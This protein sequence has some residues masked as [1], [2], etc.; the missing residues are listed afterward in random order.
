[1]TKQQ[2]D[3][4][5]KRLQAERDKFDDMICSGFVKVYPSKNQERQQLYQLMMD[6]SKSSFNEF[7]NGHNTRFTQ[8]SAFVRADPRNMSKTNPQPIKGKATDLI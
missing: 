4:K 8:P 3:A 6:F 1:M 5:R 7:T 2:R